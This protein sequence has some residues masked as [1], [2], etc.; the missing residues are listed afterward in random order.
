M[1]PARRASGRSLP[2][3]SKS[4]V[5]CS[6]RAPRWALCSRAHAHGCSLLPRYPGSRVQE[7]CPC[8]TSATETPPVG[9]DMAVV[10]VACTWLL[11]GS[12]RRPASR[13]R[14]LSPMVAAPTLGSGR[15]RP[16]VGSRLW[17][18]PGAHRDVQCLSKAKARCFAPAGRHVG[19]FAQGHTRTAAHFYHDIRDLE[20]RY[21]VPA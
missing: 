12:A 15:S 5:L 8:M 21:D 20:F 9:P 1:G 10:L 16:A 18:L 2:E 7:R 4:T 19:R 6:S 13:R 11:Y 17:G 14:L 3:Q